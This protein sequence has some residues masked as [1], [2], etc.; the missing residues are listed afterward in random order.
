MWL[1]NK[2]KNKERIK[3]VICFQAKL[4]QLRILMIVNVYIL[5]IK[6]GEKR[7][8]SKRNAV[9]WKMKDKNEEIMMPAGDDVM[10]N[11]WDWD[12]DDVS[13]NSNY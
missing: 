6:K 13:L 1:E 9:N 8:E 2:I 12:W 11:H 5:K 10:Y 7:K 3:S 4:L